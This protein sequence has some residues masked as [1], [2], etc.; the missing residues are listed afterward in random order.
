MNPP[1]YKHRKA[2]KFIIKFKYDVLKS[3]VDHSHGK[4]DTQPTPA[5]SV[6]KYEETRPI[7]VEKNIRETP[8][9]FHTEDLCSVYQEL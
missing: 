7:R 9:Y 6:Q 8:F 4:S 1:L 2:C 5:A 3:S